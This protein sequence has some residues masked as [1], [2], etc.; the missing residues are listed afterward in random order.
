MLADFF[1]KGPNSKYF[2]L[3]DHKIS[4]LVTTQLS[5]CSKKEAIDNISTDD[6]C[7]G[8]TK[9]YLQ[10]H[11]ARIA[12]GTTVCKTSANKNPKTPI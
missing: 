1:C 9:L 2:R 7:H 10:K 3:T 11:G 6:H 12:S 5:F 8:P 4:V